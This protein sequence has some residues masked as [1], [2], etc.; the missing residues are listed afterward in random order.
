MQSNF[1]FALTMSA[2]NELNFFTNRPPFELVDNEEMVG[3]AIIPK[4]YQYTAY[5]TRRK[6]S[7]PCNWSKNHSYRNK[8]DSSAEG[9]KT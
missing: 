9:R 2:E 4:P 5:G 6:D 3:V 7:H 8:Q 1:I